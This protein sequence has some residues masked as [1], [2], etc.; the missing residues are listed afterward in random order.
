MPNYNVTFSGEHC[1]LIVP[2]VPCFSDD[3]D[4]VEKEALAILRDY[5][6]GFNPYNNQMGLEEIKEVE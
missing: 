1:V 5:H 4:E 2:Y 6:L 3:E